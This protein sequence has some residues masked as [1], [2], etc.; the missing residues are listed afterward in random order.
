MR[1]IC[2][3]LI[4]TTVGL[5]ALSALAQSALP[6]VPGW[7]ALTN[8]RLMVSS[9]PQPD[10]VVFCGGSTGNPCN[11]A[12]TVAAKKNQRR[13]RILSVS[14]AVLVVDKPSGAASAPITWTLV[15]GAPIPPATDPGVFRFEEETGVD[16]ASDEDGTVFAPASAASDAITVSNMFGKPKKAFGYNV[17]VQRKL[18]S[19][20][21]IRCDSVDPV[22]VNRD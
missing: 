16:I 6:R 2:R 7:G 13:C 12:V 19:G 11:V 14:P 1:A 18:S 4:A 10:D 17:S 9:N 21:W 3:F 22:I 15:T 20:K 8:Q 5:A